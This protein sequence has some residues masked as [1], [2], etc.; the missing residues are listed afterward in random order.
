MRKAALEQKKHELVFFW[1]G[2]IAPILKHKNASVLMKSLI[3]EA[4]ELMG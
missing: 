1:S 4:N 3:E 2:Q